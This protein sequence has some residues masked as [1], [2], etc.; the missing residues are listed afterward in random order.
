M[1]Q[2][3]AETHVRSEHEHHV[4]ALDVALGLKDT[5]IVYAT[6][7]NNS[8]FGNYFNWQQTGPGDT[9][10]SA[11]DVGSPKQAF[12]FRSFASY[13]LVS[14]DGI[15]PTFSSA[16]LPVSV[17]ADPH[18]PYR[19]DLIQFVQSVKGE[20]GVPLDAYMV[21]QRPLQ[22]QQDPPNP[23]KPPSALTGIEQAG[24]PWLLRNKNWSSE[25]D[26]YRGNRH[27]KL[28]SRIERSPGRYPKSVYLWRPRRSAL[29][30]VS[31]GSDGPRV[32]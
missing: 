15:S 30:C 25:P 5:Q 19:A 1:V 32:V 22:D 26:F 29:F 20:D 3:S 24:N 2:N 31:L 7:D 4:Q 13:N 18:Q 11:A 8:W 17:L 16:T 12:L 14:L 21:V 27:W 9:N 28:G 10:S 23:I 6:Q